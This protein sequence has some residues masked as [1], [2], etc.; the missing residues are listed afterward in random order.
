MPVAQW[1]EEVNSMNLPQDLF[2]F[3]LSCHLGSAY[4]IHIYKGKMIKYDLGEGE[5]QSVF[6]LWSPPALTVVLVVGCLGGPQN[7]LHLC[8][9]LDSSQHLPLRRR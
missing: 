4:Y 8:L 9:Q 5:P 6:C 7:I 2:P 3:L 1:A